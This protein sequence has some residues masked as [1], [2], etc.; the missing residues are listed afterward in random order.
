MAAL[1]A[2]LFSGGI[3]F[4]RAIVGLAA[5]VIA[6]VRAVAAFAFFSLWMARRPVQRAWFTERATL[7]P[8]IGLGLTLGATAM[9]YIF[10]LQHTT[11]ANAVLLNNS[12][13]LYVALLAPWFLHEARP[14]YTWFS[15]ILAFAGVLCVINLAELDVHSGSALGVAAAIIS[16]FSYAMT[17]LVSRRLRGRVPSLAQVWLGMI[18]AAFVA[19]PWALTQSWATLAANWHLCVGLG[20]ISLGLPYMLFFQSLQRVPAQIVSVVGLLEPV[21]GVLIGILLYDEVHGP[22][23]LLGIALVLASIVLISR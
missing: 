3:I 5:P 11:A 16:G 18:V 8:L 23:G 15:L 22:L 7:G 14:R 20:I 13:P 6:V 21:S 9:L 2:L 19:L 17:M 10:A 12:A 1:G 4:T